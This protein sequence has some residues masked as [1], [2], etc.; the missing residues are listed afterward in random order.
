MDLTDAQWQ[1][2][3]PLIPI[4]KSGTDKGGR[5][6]LPARQVLCGILWILRTGA[7]WKDLP[8]RYPSYQTCHRRFQ[9]WVRNGTLGR[10]LRA[11]AK[12]L[13]CRGKIDLSECFI[14]GTFS[15]AK[16]GGL[17]LVKRSAEK[18]PRSWQLQTATVF[19]S[20]WALRALRPT[21][22]LS[23]SR[24]FRTAAPGANR[25]ESLVTKPM[26]ATLLTSALPVKTSS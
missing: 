25:C 24:S 5:P 7:R 6:A 12:D 13:E 19:L 11:L 4:S 15:P 9:V 3:E 22:S 10:I 21:K 16:K 17:L 18:G 8:D 2:L 20:P 23:S 14:D 1:L 26:T